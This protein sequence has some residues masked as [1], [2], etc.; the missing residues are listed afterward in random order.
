MRV[1]DKQRKRGVARISRRI[2]AGTARCAVAMPS[3]AVNLV[4][5]L[6]QLWA[7]AAA[8]SLTLASAVNR[9]KD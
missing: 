1:S 7:S 5:T 8:L 6:P 2:V 9:P 3:M 4:K